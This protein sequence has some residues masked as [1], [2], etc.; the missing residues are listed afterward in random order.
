MQNWLYPKMRK[1]RFWHLYLLNH[2]GY[3]IANVEE[4]KKI[5]NDNSKKELYTPVV[6]R[7]K[8]NTTMFS[9]KYV[10]NTG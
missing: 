8:V 10:L 6:Y 3:N 4:E 5:P 2:F 7:F 9:L 1:V